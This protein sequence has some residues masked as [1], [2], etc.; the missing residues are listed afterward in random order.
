MRAVWLDVALSTVLSGA[1]LTGLGRSCPRAPHDTQL[2]TSTALPL[3]PPCTPQ[4]GVPAKAAVSLVTLMEGGLWRGWG[5]SQPQMSLCICWEG[6]TSWPDSRPGWS[7]PGDRPCLVRLLSPAAQGEVRRRT[8]SPREPID[9]GGR[10]AP[11]KPRSVISNRKRPNR[12]RQ[13]ITQMT[14]CRPDHAVPESFPTTPLPHYGWGAQ[15]GIPSGG[16][17]GQRSWKKA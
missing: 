15:P 3:Q 2:S 11:L 14:C 10:Q 7:L 4:P 6:H 9:L 8:P 16:G 13:I 5:S 12:M 17:V 1:G